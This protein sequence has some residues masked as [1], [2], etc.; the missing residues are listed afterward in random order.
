ML[1][2]NDECVVK[3]GV[4]FIEAWMGNGDKTTTAGAFARDLAS[5]SMVNWHFMLTKVTEQLRQDKLFVSVAF[6]YRQSDAG[7]SNQIVCFHCNWYQFAREKKRMTKRA[8]SI[9][10][11]APCRSPLIYD[12]RCCLLLIKKK[13]LKRIWKWFSHWFIFIFYNSA[14][15]LSGNSSKKFRRKVYSNSTNVAQNS[16]CI[17]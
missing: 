9:N 12:L 17:I 5:V 16:V 14:L 10:R 13:G 6:H 2:L 15:A 3:G 11:S 4:K 1:A 7:L 8:A